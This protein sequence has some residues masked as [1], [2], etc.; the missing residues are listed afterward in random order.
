M[1][2]SLA[3]WLFEIWLEVLLSCPLLLPV[4]IL[5]SALV[6]PGGLYVPSTCTPRRLGDPARV[7]YYADGVPRPVSQC[8]RMMCLMAT[9]APA[10]VSLK[11]AGGGDRQ[12]PNPV[13][14]QA[15]AFVWLAQVFLL[16]SSPPPGVVK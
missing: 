3:G 7:Q 5:Q 2:A 15:T 14:E 13:G 6:P 4:Q 10:G 8:V 11:R 9:H 16:V 1:K 12:L